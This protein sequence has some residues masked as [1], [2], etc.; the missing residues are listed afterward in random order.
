VPKRTTGDPKAVLVP[1]PDTTGRLK[2][3]FQRLLQA[4]AK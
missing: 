4:G 1:K 2:K 3:V